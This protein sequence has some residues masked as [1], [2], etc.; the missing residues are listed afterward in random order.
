MDVAFLGLRVP[1][2][3][4]LVV[5]DPSDLLQ[6][7]KKTKLPGIIGWNLVRLEYQEFINK[8]PVK[9]FDNFQCP[10]NIDPLLFSQLCVYYYTDIR[11]AVV[12]EVIEGDYIYTESI[13]TNLDGE[14][15]HKK[16]QHLNSLLDGP[17]G[18]VQIG[19]TRNQFVFLEMPC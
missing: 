1:R 7:K 19:M 18:M 12:T 14:V 4:F 17:V 8:Y 6:T 3:G 10:Q 9:V 2:V 16:H 5:K 15:V 11:P 13:T